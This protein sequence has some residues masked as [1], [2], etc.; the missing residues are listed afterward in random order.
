MNNTTLLPP[1]ADDAERALDLAT[2]RVG[3]VPV[4]VREA[5][6]PDTCP[7]SLLPWLAWAFSVDEWNPVWTDT[8]KREAIKA[9]AFVHRHKGTVG[10]MK[11]ALHAL[12]YDLELQ[13]WHQMEPQGDPYTFGVNITLEQTGI[14]TAQQWDQ[15]EAVA[16][17]AKNVR[18]H[19][20]GIKIT[21]IT[22]AGIYFGGVA[23]CGE[24]LTISAEA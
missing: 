3:G 20:S 5:W 9:S 22:R 7:A 4:L 21:A 16:N 19:M 18:S 8:Q 1:S 17:S 10:A 23:L 13:E 14:P 12:G 2:A 6:T 24:T 15:V 11:K